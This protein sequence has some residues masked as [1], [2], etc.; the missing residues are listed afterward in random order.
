[1]RYALQVQVHLLNRIQPMSVPWDKGS[2]EFLGKGER[3]EERKGD[4]EQVGGVRSAH[5]TSCVELILCTL[6]NKVCTQ[7]Y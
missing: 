2:G 3:E 4:G 5:M 7:Q 1:M 6:S